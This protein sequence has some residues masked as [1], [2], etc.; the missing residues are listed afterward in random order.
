MTTPVEF[1]SGGELV[2]AF[3]QGDAVKIAKVHKSFLQAA[4]PV[5]AKLLGC[6]FKEGHEEYSLANPLSFP[7][8]DPTAML[9]L[10]RV[11]HWRSKSVDV[12]TIDWL[13][14]LA[15]VCDK[16][17]CADCLQDFFQTR[18]EKAVLSEVEKYLIFHLTGNQDQFGDWSSFL[19]RNTKD[20]I[21]SSC[22]K[23]FLQLLPK[24]LLDELAK[25]RRLARYEYALIAQIPM[26]SMHTAVREGQLCYG[27]E[28]KLS[29]YWRLLNTHKVV[30]ADGGGDAYLPDLHHVMTQVLLEN[31]E[32]PGHLRLVGALAQKC[33]NTSNSACGCLEWKLGDQISSAA[34]RIA[35]GRADKL[36]LCY[37][38]FQAGKTT[39]ANLCKVHSLQQ[40]QK[41]S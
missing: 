28:K 38:C 29:S 19:V 18:I 6:Q 33:G 15:V 37:S 27:M 25:Y 14:K 41:F 5:L 31:N 12:T 30:F 35:Y 10:C 1:V 34:K 36:K 8:D 32:R 2:V 39:F 20:L 13:Q 26:Q 7:E 16:Y 17:Q 24:G 4:S 21:E 3:G 9:N 11:V 40:P 23:E 22:H